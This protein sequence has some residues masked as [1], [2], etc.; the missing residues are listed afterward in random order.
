MYIYDELLHFYYIFQLVSNN[1]ILYKLLVVLFYFIL[2][3]EKKIK[4]QKRAVRLI[5]NTK[6][7]T[8]NDPIF[9]K[10]NILKI[11]NMVDFNQAMFMFKYTNGLLPDSFENIFKKLGNFDRSLSYQVDLLNFLRFGITFLLN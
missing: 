2:T 7:M 9:L 10:Y 1:L 11:N 5:D 6:T 4:Q 3:Y 8:H